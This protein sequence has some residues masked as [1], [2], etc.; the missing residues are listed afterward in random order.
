MVGWGF[1]HSSEPVTFDSVSLRLET[2]AGGPVVDKNTI[3]LG[4][5]S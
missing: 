2:D 3:F 1:V 5:G 4:T